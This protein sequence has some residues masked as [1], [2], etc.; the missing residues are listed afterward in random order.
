MRR[1]ARQDDFAN[2]TDTSDIGGP[3]RG[4][5]IPRVWVCTL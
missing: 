1:Y 5:A 3:D 4:T 2:V